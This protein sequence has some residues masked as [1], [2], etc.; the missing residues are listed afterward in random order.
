M[1]QRLDTLED[2]VQILVDTPEEQPDRIDL[3]EFLRQKLQLEQ[4]TADYSR[5]AKEYKDSARHWRRTNEWLREGAKPLLDW[6]LRHKKMCLNDATESAITLQD[7]IGTESED[8]S[9]APPDDWKP[10][11]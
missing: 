1:E 8:W 9:A 2:R 4:K 10:N 3:D 11:E 5:L 6:I 7:R